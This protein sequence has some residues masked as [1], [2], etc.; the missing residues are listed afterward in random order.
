MPPSGADATA[1]HRCR[2]E[3]DAA[4]LGRLRVG[5]LANRGE[6]GGDGCIVVL[7]LALR[8][9]WYAGMGGYNYTPGAVSKGSPALQE[10]LPYAEF[11]R[12][13]ISRVLVILLDSRV[14]RILGN[15]MSLRL[16][17]PTNSAMIHARGAPT[18]LT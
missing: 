5:E 8:R 3:A 16:V 18:F 1:S 12:H 17:G 6:D 9:V 2:G 11:C 7:V 10:Y 15:A 14:Q 4:A 13:R